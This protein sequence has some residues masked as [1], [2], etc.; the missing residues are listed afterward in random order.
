MNIYEDQEDAE[1][2][3]TAT[4]MDISGDSDIEETVRRE[5]E[6]Y[7]SYELDESDRGKDVPAI[8]QY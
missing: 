1:V 4:V 3:I 7:S 6:D 2:Q 5:Q 8:N